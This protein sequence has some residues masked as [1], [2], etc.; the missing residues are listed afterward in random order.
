MRLRPVPIALGVLGLAVGV[1][2]VLA[3]REATL[4]TH[5][6]DDPD[7]RVAVVVRADTERSEPGQSRAE[8]VEA[9]FLTCRLEVTADVVGPI[10]DEGD[11]RYRAVLSPALD[12]TDERQLRGCVEDWTIDHLRVDVL[13]FEPVS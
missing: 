3:L 10:V 5:A 4:S 12:A 13:G 2:G 6:P 7:S 11:G 1:V 8:M 9:L